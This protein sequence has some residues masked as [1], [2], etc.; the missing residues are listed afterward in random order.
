M[1]LL[2]ASFG[3]NGVEQSGPAAK[4]VSF[5]TAKDSFMTTEILI[6]DRFNCSPKDLYALLTDNA[7]DDELMKALNVGKE[8]ISSDKKAIGPEYK[9][10]L[11]SAEE[12]PAIAK[13][14]VGDHLSY[15]ETRCW[16]D[17]KCA[18]TWVILPEVKGATVEAKGTTD[19]VA[20]GDGC[21]RRTKGSITV[22]LPLI[23]GK[24]EEMVKKSICDTFS[25]NADYCRKHLDK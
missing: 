20:D 9:I 19:I 8:L 13:K 3:H 6:E 4:P 25:K 5:F 14:F 11:T 22:K 10:R 24:I 7:F 1:T 21:I 12:I 16:N 15:V 23:G 17:A 18:N 2:V